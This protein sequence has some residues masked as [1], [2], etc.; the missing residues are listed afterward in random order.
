[1]LF[2]RFNIPPYRIFSKIER[3]IMSKSIIENTQRYGE[4]FNNA[5]TV[6]KLDKNMESI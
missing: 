6:F 2:C 1:M 3:E 4:I 5:G